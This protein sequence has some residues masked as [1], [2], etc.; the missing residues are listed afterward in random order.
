L[1]DEIILTIEPRLFGSGLSLFSDNV[2]VNLELLEAKKI[3]DSSIMLKY[4]VIY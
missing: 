3:N 2:N 4:K 1:I